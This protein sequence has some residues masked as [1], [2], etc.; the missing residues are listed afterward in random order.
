MK[1]KGEGKV[2]PLGE[3]DI[4]LDGVTPLYQLVLEYEIEI[5]EAT[6]VSCHWPALQGILYESGMRLYDIH[7]IEVY[8]EVLFFLEDF[9][10]QFFM[11][12]DESKK[13]LSCGD[14]W[15]KKKKL[16]KG[17][18]IVRL[19]VRHEK[20]AVLE[21]VLSLPMVF[22]RALKNAIT[23]TAY[24]TKSEALVGAE[25]GLLS[26]RS[27]SI[28][29]SLVLYFKEPSSDTLPKGVSNGDILT[30]SVTYMKKEPGKGDR[31]GGYKV[32]YV[33]FDCSTETNGGINKKDAISSEKEK[34][35]AR[36][37]EAKMK[38]IKGLVGDPAFV[39]IADLISADYPEDISLKALRVNHFNK[40]LEAATPSEEESIT[41]ACLLA[42][43]DV[44]QNVNSA[45]LA[46]AFGVLTPVVTK[47]QE[48]QKAALVMALGSKAKILISRSD[49]N[50][51]EF[52][53]VMKEL[54]KWAS[55]TD[56]KYWRLM[57]GKHM[58]SKK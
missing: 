42:I 18:L 48:T 36:M 37:K 7:T 51:K 56:H 45:E 54:Q 57:Y 34:F 3:R 35:S 40:L 22:V 15:P 2:F 4:L 58:A 20:A 6:E 29:S 39:E 27:F 31:P 32:D 30:G 26:G 53:D 47:N 10:G 33:F 52:E 1:P 16:P 5:S 13:L 50:L 55:L 21:K 14:A 43:D 44:I 12:F 17:K 19:Q 49:V 25:S 38:H 8:F 28:G 24:K 9:H 11:V 41:D 46:Q 23:I